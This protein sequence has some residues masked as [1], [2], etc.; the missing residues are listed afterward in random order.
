ME[1]QK[2]MKKTYYARNQS[3]NLLNPSDINSV[4]FDSCT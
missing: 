3:I 1:K 4:Y 2:G